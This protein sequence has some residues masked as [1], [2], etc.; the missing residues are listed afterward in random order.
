MNVMLVVLG[1]L[2]IVYVIRANHFKRINLKM[3]KCFDNLW[4]MRWKYGTEVYPYEFNI[5]RQDTL[6]PM[7]QLNID[8]QVSGVRYFW[9]T[10]GVG[11]SRLDFISIITNVYRRETTLT[12][13]SVTLVLDDGVLFSYGP[14]SIEV[15]HY[16]IAKQF[17]DFLIT[18]K[19]RE[20]ITTI[21]L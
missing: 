19:I 10:F 7:I 14:K 1:A 6:P 17:H 13:D 21:A 2:I 16:T 5:V 11:D 3:Q 9:G 4:I 20:N 12:V 8:R 15:S 18:L